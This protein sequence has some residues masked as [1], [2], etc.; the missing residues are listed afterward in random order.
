MGESI[1][2]TSAALDRYR[3]A[4]EIDDVQVEDALMDVLERADA[5]SA[6]LSGDRSRWGVGVAAVGVAIAAAA[7]VGLWLGIELGAGRTTASGAHEA[8]YTRSI[9]TLGGHLQ[10]RV[11]DPPPEPEP[12]STVPAVAVVP[13]PAV[14]KPREAPKAPRAARDSKRDRGDRSEVG[15][16]TKPDPAP[17]VLDIV[18]L[19]EENRLLRRARRALSGGE[20]EEALRWTRRHRRAFPEPVLLEER[21]VIESVA[22]CRTGRAAQGRESA[23]QLRTRFPNSPTLSRVRQAC[24]ESE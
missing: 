24:T 10:R 22:L 15:P 8:T 12:P 9:P 19:K 17:A 4:T 14:E 7:A 3:E 5:V 11:D 16:R 18:D 1:G 13:A 20:P 23:A 6:E 2:P 21:L